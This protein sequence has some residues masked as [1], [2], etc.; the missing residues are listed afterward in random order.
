M[1][2]LEGDED[3]VKELYKSISMDN[4]HSSVAIL[5]QG[6]I[7]QKSFGEWSMACKLL[8]Q[9]SAQKLVPGFEKLDQG[10]TPIRMISESPNR[11]KRTFLR[12]RD[13]L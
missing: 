11:G 5:Y 10:K 13:T 8:D 6:A 3:V 7:E 4:R 12:L 9:D 1:Q 2:I